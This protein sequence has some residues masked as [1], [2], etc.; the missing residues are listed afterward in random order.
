MVRFVDHDW[1]A[2]RA[3]T[4]ETRNLRSHNKSKAWMTILAS[5]NRC[6][7]CTH[8]DCLEIDYEIYKKIRDHETMQL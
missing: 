2:R 3:K 7:L 8:D 4:I 5:L 1:L 6:V